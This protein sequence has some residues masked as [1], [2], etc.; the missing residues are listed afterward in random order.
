LKL[1]VKEAHM[2]THIAPL[3]AILLMAMLALFV[4]APVSALPITPVSYDMK[5]GGS[6]SY[7][8]WDESY[9][10]SGSTPTNYAQL[11][12][13]RGDL[14]DGIIANS[15]YYVTEAPAGPGPYVGW[16]INPTITFHFGSVT[17]LNSLT[18][19]LDDYNGGG[20]YLPG[21][22]T[23]GMGG[24][25]SIYTVYDDPAL[26]KALPVTFSN[27]GFSGDTLTLTLTRKNDYWLFLSEVTFDGTPIGTQSLA[28]AAV[29]E[30]GTM[31]LLGA[32]LLGL[33]GYN[34]RRK[35][36]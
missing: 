25:T 5:N 28:A 17:N 7:Q 19:Y 3:P 26:S 20:V 14:S 34:W 10:G 15:H 9:S 4:A 31:L 32:G 18:L 36:A 22:V 11:I 33:A 24:A 6:A 8:Y 13:G 30:P 16:R 21:S 27:L 1:S 2:K 35:R 12:G 29:P 23:L